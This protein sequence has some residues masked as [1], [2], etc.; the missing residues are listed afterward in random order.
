MDTFSALATPVRRRIL[1]LLA[2]SGQ[3]SAGEI[4]EHFKITPSAISQHLKVLL[5]ARL[6]RFEKQGQMR[7]YAVEPGPML[8][9]ARWAV[10][11]G[12]R[13]DRLDALLQAEK[14]K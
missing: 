2:T 8:E 3:L 11:M 1:E 7:L 12:Q 5:E 13:Y 9:L 10:Q 4:C 6:V 14:A